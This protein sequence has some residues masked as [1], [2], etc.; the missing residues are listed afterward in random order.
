MK[1]MV[2]MDA[3]GWSGATHTQGALLKG[4]CGTTD[5][6][7]DEVGAM[8]QP[9]LSTYLAVW[10]VRAVHLAIESEQP[11]AQTAHDLGVHAQTLHTWVR[12]YPHVR[13]HAQQD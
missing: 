13:Q 3:C 7:T 5:D 11:I 2:S 10:K 1:T 4:G 8:R 9:T 6:E 12:A